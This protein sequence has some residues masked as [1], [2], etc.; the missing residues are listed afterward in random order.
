M[1]TILYFLKG[2]RSPGQQAYKKWITA[3]PDY[4]THIGSTQKAVCP[5]HRE[6]Q[7]TQGAD[8]DA[9]QPKCQMEIFVAWNSPARR[10]LSHERG[11]SDLK[12][13]L[14]RAFNDELSGMNPPPQLAMP[15]LEGDWWNAERHIYTP[16]ICKDDALRADSRR[17]PRLFRASDPDADMGTWP[18]NPMREDEITQ[19]YACEGSSLL[20]H[21]WREMAYTDGSPCVRTRSHSSMHVRAAA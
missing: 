16:G 7:W 20:R 3:Y 13:E 10:E 1:A 12:Q 9:T 17:A 15:N 18:S 21:A 4:F 2:L 14:Q 6:D 19:Q 5:L 11:L 8:T